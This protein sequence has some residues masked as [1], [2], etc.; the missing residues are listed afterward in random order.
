[1]SQRRRIKKKNKSGEQLE[2]QIETNMY[3]CFECEE[4]FEKET[5]LNVIC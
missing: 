2:K 1:M 4:V 3:K 5:G